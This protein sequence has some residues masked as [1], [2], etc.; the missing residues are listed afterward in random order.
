MTT[1]TKPVRRPP[2]I[3]LGLPRS[4]PALIT[5]AQS[6]LKRMTGNPSF[7][8]PAP[9]LA[10]LTAALDDLQAAQTAALSRL[11]G[12][13]AAREEKRTVLIG[14][15]EQLRTYIQA[16]AD[17]DPTNAASIIE[18]AGLNPRKVP[19]RHARVFA[20][21]PG[22][23]SGVVKVV[24]QA[25]GRRAAYEWQYSTDG[26]TWIALPSTLQAKTTITGLLPGSTMQVKYRALT[27]TGEGDWSQPLSMMVH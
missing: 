7:P 14:V 19:A 10:T 4:V 13:V 1:T 26:K 2:R 23:L 22:L 15:L 24:A 5:I 20:T 6:V 3:R 17:A 12:A 18:S 27:K 16:I 25:A 9:S 8:N 21:K 11:K